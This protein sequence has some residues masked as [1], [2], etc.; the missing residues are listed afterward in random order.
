M[1]LHV[2]AFDEFGVPAAHWEVMGGVMGQV[3]SQVAQDES[4]ENGV[5]PERCLKKN[6]DH[7]IK[8]SIEDRSQWNCDDRRHDEAGLAL[9]LGMVNAVEE[10]GDA[11]TSFRFGGKVEKETVQQIFRDGPDEKPNQQAEG[12]VE[13]KTFQ[14]CFGNG[15]EQ[16]KERH[17][18][19][20]DGD[21]HRAD[22]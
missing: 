9:R 17:R 21:R 6:L 2:V 5:K 18:Q 12:D 4:R 19:P 16:E 1:M 14:R 10:K 7:Q 13:G 20:D 15:T 11:L 22:M 8:Q 3:I